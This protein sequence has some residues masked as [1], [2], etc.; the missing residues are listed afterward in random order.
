M[1]CSFFSRQL[2][3][4]EQKFSATELEALAL[5]ETIEH[6]KLY[7]AGRDF[8][9]F[10]DHQALSGVLDGVPPSSK[11]ARWKHK[12]AEYSVNIVYIK[13]AQ[14][15]VADSLSRQGWPQPQQP[16]PHLSQQQQ[17]PLPSSPDTPLFQGGGDVVE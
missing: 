6:F 9:A 2:L 15:P 17:Q 16:L 3:P 12:L 8:V 1:P 11:L 7:L 5:L 13:G 10:T 4:R 14:N